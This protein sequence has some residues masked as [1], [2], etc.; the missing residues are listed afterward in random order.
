M[1]H[2]HVMCDEIEPGSLRMGGHGHCNQHLR[3]VEL[4]VFSAISVTE[5]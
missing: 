4:S 1:F 3:T 2:D 5:K